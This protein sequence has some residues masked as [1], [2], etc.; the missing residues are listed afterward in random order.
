[1]FPIGISNFSQLFSVEWIIVH[2]VFCALNSVA[3]MFASVKFILA[4]QQSGYKTKRFFRWLKSPE[5]PYLSRLM[6]LCLLGFLFFLVLN[7]CFSP[8]VG[9]EAGSF[10]GLISYFIFVF[11]YIKSESAVN[12]KI[13]LRKTRR[14]ITLCVTYTILIAVFTFLLII[15]FNYLAYVIQNEMLAILRYALICGMPILLPYILYLAF[16][17]NQPFETCIKR[18]Y[19]KRTAQK[20]DNANVIKIGITGSFGKT[21]VKEI[22]KTILSVKYRVLATPASYNT[23]MGICLT[24]NGLDNT[25]D[26]FI[27]EMG[28]RNIGDIKNLCNLVK[29]KYALLTGVNNQHLESFG[30]YENILKAKN[31]IFESLSADGVGFFSSDNEGAKTLYEKCEKEKYFAGISGGE[32]C[33]DNLSIS[34]NGTDFLLKIKGEEPIKCNTV[35]L[36]KHSISNICLAVALAYKIGLT[37]KEIA[38]GINRIQTVNHRLELVPN[39]KGIV[40]IDDSYNSNEDGIKSAMEVLDT[41]KGRKIVLTPG[42]VELGKRENIAN[43]ELGKTLAN[44]ADKVIV[45]G[46]HN[47]EMIIQG[48]IDGGMERENI[49]FAK[50]LNK[51]N[52]LLNEI[53][54]KGDVVLFENDLPDNYS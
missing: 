18:K 44:H 27:A 48:L 40:L 34:E 36:G 33:A 53:L 31:E 43:F 10:V 7:T 8:L 14:L 39:N 17:I 12:A 13:P 30:C 41:F 38:L 47:A 9:V 19:L 32:V 22:L 16:C 26:V 15:L 1:M 49:S 50:T 42:L 45:I 51:G 54:E 24:V 46:K 35:L 5:T 3:L 2:L 6:L 20:L 52:A 28:A 4:M 29:P 37:P 23:S 21:S 25:H 11:L